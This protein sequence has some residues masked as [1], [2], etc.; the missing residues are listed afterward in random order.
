MR[1]ISVLS[2]AAQAAAGL[3]C[4]CW[5]ELLH[6]GEVAVHHCRAHEPLTVDR[7]GRVVELDP[8]TV[9]I[10]HGDDASDDARDLFEARYQ[11]SA[12]EVRVHLG[13]RPW[14]V[15]QVLP[16]GSRRITVD[17]IIRADL[18]A[19]VEGLH[20]CV[21]DGEPH[22]SRGDVLALLDGAQP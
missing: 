4:G 2:D 10:A 14:T 6:A 8:I 16:D 19:K 11:R 7:P 20:R 12:D 21:I 17:P 1:E 18:R 3:P 13:L 9:A 22:V 5:M 15:D